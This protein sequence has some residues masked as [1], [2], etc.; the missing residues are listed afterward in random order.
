MTKDTHRTS[1]GICCYVRCAIARLRLSIAAALVFA[2]G[3]AAAQPAA[4]PFPAGKPVSIHV[5]TEAGGTNDQIMRIVA[6]HLGKYLPG[7]PTV[8]PRNTPG[9]GGRRLAALL[10]NTA[11][12]DGTELGALQRGL[13]TD[14]LLIDSPLPFKVP[15]LTWIGTPSGTTDLCV[16][17]HRARV[18]TWQ[19]SKRPSW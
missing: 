2:C 4:A 17:W 19:I 7:N 8:V 12:R 10:S 18:Q 3:G 9:A 13:T 14:G 15:E 6:R 5:G 16:V 11:P 1:K